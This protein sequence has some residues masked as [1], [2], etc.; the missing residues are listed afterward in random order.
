[1]GLEKKINVSRK[2]ISRLLKNRCSI[3]Q[4]KLPATPRKLT[5][6]CKDHAQL[7]AEVSFKVS[8]LFPINIF[9]LNFI[10]NSLLLKSV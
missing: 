7:P 3:F 8:Y 2:Q 6:L 9:L 1:M 4:R 10:G 5:L